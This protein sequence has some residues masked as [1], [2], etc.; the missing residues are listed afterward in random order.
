MD[1]GITSKEIKGYQ[2]GFSVTNIFGR[3]NWKWCTGLEFTRFPK[4]PIRVGVS[5]GGKDHRQLSFGSG[6]HAGFIHLDWALG[7][8]HG[9]WFTTAKGIDFS[10]V[11]YTTGRRKEH[12]Q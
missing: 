6:Y 2:F 4:L 5:F 3:I 9:L 8:N 7:L 10:F 11:V 1:F 12:K